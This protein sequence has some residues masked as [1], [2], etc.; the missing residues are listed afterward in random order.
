MT[1]KLII[2]KE[3]KN[4][5]QVGLNNSI[6]DVIL[7]GSQASG[8]ASDESDYDVLIVLNKDYDAKTENKIY[9]LCYE[10]ELKYNI[11][12]DVS[13]I[14]TKELITKRGKQPLFISAMQK[15]LYA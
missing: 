12:I 4:T 2:I 15:G 13:I 10:I 5:L 9:D 7:F 8:K 14:S 6:K 11:I 1:D 3:L